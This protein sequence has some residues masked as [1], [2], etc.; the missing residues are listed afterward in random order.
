MIQNDAITPEQ[1]SM[2]LKIS[3]RNC[4]S[5][6][7]IINIIKVDL[8]CIFFLYQ[9]YSLTLYVYKTKIYFCTCF[10]SAPNTTPEINLYFFPTQ[11][12]TK[13][14]LSLTQCSKTLIV[15]FKTINSK[16][17]NYSNDLSEI[18][19]SYLYVCIYVKCLKFYELLKLS[20]KKKKIYIKRKNYFHHF[21]T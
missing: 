13:L 5:T 20:K 1:N 6:N 2:I 19:P 8:C 3:S 17:L 16:Y 14:H 4:T 9:F 12:K 21:S 15:Y 18:S 10:Q 11:K 7:F